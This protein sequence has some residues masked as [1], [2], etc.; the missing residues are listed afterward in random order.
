[1][2]EVTETCK[3]RMKFRFTVFIFGFLAL[4]VVAGRK[5]SKQVECFDVVLDAVE[6]AS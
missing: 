6:K 4:I 3:R 5:L 1:M 2:S